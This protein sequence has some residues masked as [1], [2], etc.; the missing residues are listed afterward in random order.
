MFADHPRCFADLDRLCVVSSNVQAGDEFRGRAATD[1]QYSSGLL[2]RAEKDKQ[3]GWWRTQEPVRKTEYSRSNGGYKGV[4]SG[5]TVTTATSVSYTHLCKG[6]LAW[7]CG[8][9]PVILNS[10]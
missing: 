10:V 3:G 5:K 8:W 9:G 2:G 6:C 4:A 1:V 7:A